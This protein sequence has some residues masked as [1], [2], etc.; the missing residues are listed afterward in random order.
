MRI[1]KENMDV[2]AKDWNPFG[3]NDIIEETQAG[4][5]PYFAKADTPLAISTTAVWRAIFGKVGWWWVNYASPA[6]GAL[7]KVAWD[8]SGDRI[9]RADPATAACQGVTETGALPDA[10]VPTFLLHASQF[11]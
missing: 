7:R 10:Q 11:L 4:L 2:L 1:T 6:F 9:V 3:Y 8:K 5:F